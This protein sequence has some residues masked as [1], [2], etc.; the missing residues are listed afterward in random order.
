MST[1]RR[2][3]GAV[4]SFQTCCS[5]REK[6]LSTL[7]DSRIPQTRCSVFF[8]TL[9]GSVDSPYV[10]QQ[11][12]PQR[13]CTA[14]GRSRCRRQHT[15]KGWEFPGNTPS[16]LGQEKLCLYYISWNL[17]S[18]TIFSFLTGRVDSTHVCK[19]VWPQRDCTAAGRSR[20]RCQR[21][22]KGWELCFPM[23]S[24]LLICCWYMLQILYRPRHFF[25]SSQK[26]LTALMCA[27]RFGH[28]EIAQL[29]VDQGA[30]VNTLDNVRS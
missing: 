2:G 20:C 26:G 25:L 3:L 12:W 28:G 19:Q 18:T 22:G 16:I 4:I 15:A 23:K 10:C 14:A 24:P 17:Q 6:T 11:V 5:I 27:S 1:H 9:A 13:D 30:D 29:L 8:L 7:Q 21:T